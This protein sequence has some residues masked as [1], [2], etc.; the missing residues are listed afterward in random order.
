[1]TKANL[2]L[3]LLAGAS[4]SAATATAQT[5]TTPTHHAAS[6]AAAH[7]STTGTRTPAA[8]GCITL[9]TL[10]PKIP[11][12]PTGSPCPKAMF[13]VSERLDTISPMVGPEVRENFSTLPMIFTLGYVD[14]RVGTGEP[15]KPH[16]WYTVQYTGYLVD[17]TK[18]DSSYDHPDK[19]PI[20]FPYGA[21]RV[22]PGWDMGFEG[23]HVGG[24]RRLFVPYQLAY[25]ANGHP[26]TIPAKAE[27]VFDM[28]LVSQSAEDPNPRPVPPAGAPPAGVPPGGRQVLPGQ[29][30][31]VPPASITPGSV[32]P[33]G[34]APGSPSAPGSPTTPPPAA[35]PATPPASTTQP[36]ATP[37]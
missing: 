1:M 3:L 10:S 17:G 14:T 20:S 11:A 16:M 30:G 28:E 18:F 9:P 37:Q 7:R 12:L 5:S 19:K 36:H 15:A 13:T 6:T 32:P 22:I 34:A 31:A 35:A 21:H 27:L 8:G 23:M 4:V 24:K 26:P 33:A 29:P 25:G 2:S